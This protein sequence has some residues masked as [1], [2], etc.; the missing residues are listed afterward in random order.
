MTCPWLV[1][2]R[3]AYLLHSPVRTQCLLL[4][5]PFSAAMW[6]RCCEMLTKQAHHTLNLLYF[7]LK[8]PDLQICGEI[9]LHFLY[10]VQSWVFCYSSTDILGFPRWTAHVLWAKIFRHEPTFILPWRDGFTCLQRSQSPREL[11]SGC[12]VYLSAH[13]GRTIPSWTDCKWDMTIY[14]CGTG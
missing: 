8:L 7:T 1:P 3:R 11:P 4:F 13:L 14:S 2:P 6:W 9:H 12:Y 10:S 5:S